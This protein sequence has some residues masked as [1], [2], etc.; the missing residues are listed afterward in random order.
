M[1]ND[2]RRAL[3]QCRFG[4]QPRRAARICP[5]CG[6]IARA[7]KSTRELTYYRFACGAPSYKQSRSI[8]AIEQLRENPRQPHSKGCDSGQ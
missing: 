6:S 3:R 2:P 5:C 1:N 7:Y 8:T 4:S